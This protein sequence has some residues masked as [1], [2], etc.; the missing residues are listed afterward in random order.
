[1]IV[2]WTGL[3]GASKTTSLARSAIKIL[4]RNQSLYYAS[5]GKCLRK[6]WSNI[7]FSS[8][9]ESEF[10]GFIEYWTDVEQLTP[11]RDVDVIID[12]AMVY[13]DSR[14]WEHLSLDIRRWLAQHRKFGIEIYFTAQEFAQV[15]IAFRRLVSDLFWLTKMAGSRDISATLPP[16][17]FIW[18]IIMSRSIDPLAY[19]E[20][21]SKISM[22]GFPSFKLISRK[23]CEVFNT[24]QEI[25]SSKFP[26]LKHIERFCTDE[27]CSFKKLVHV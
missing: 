25:K 19:D 27:N 9:V 18:G 5:E 3:P 8:D 15:D 21:I 10:R 20:K 16:P 13:F 6:L 1:M 17:R 24:R 26:P 7:K 4:Y 14:S 23:D 11:L 22:Q 12:E 2:G